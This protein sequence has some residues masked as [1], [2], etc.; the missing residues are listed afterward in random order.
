MVRVTELS[1]CISHLQSFSPPRKLSTWPKVWNRSGSGPFAPSMLG[2]LALYTWYGRGKP[3]SLLIFEMARKIILVLRVH[4][5][6]I[7]FS[8]LSRALSKLDLL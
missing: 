7:G 2:D 3:V 5:V 8:L 6:D 1:Q 4:V